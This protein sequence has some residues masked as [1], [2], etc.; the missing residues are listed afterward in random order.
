MFKTK[1]A[2]LA[3]LSLLCAGSALAQPPAGPG[4]GPQGMGRG[5]GN[6]AWH[7]E[8]CQDREAAAAARLAYLEAKLKP[9]AAQKPLFDK[10][11]QALLDSAAKEKAACL[12]V[13]PPAGGPPSIVEREAHLQAM[14]SAKLQGLQNSHAALQALYDSLTPAQR[15][16]LDRPHHGR[17]GKGGEGWGMHGGYGP[18]G[19][20]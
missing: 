7:A 17:H 18:M 16:I 12:S 6:P 15:E 1:I 8:M 9:T 4:G 19:P 10:W 2:L 5:P 14:L 11:R 20:R 3:A 13:T